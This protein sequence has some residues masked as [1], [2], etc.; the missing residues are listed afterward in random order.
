MSLIVQILFGSAI[1]LLSALIHVAALA[2]GIT[3]LMRFG[4]WIAQHPLGLRRAM[5]L[6]A[7]IIVILFAHTLEVW[8]WALALFVGGVFSEFPI[9]FYFATATY[10]TLG[11][12]DVVLG[13]DARVFASFA[14]ITGLL[15]FGLS[16][17]FLIELVTRVFSEL[18]DQG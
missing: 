6:S 5:L 9:S 16:T 1:L 13:P 10:T 17:A 18:F 12:G 2:W 7:G 8:L 15:T 4:G 14:A 3:A 11:Y